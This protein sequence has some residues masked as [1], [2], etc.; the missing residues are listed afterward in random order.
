M[1]TKIQIIVGAYSL[2]YLNKD[3][4]IFFSIYFLFVSRI[5]LQQNLLSLLRYVIYLSIS[6]SRLESLNP[7]ANGLLSIL[8][9][10]I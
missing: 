2:S 1:K 7:L 4:S 3:K 8:S 10:V 5:I 9:L 6:L